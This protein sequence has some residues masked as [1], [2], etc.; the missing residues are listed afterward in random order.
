MKSVAWGDRISEWTKFFVPKDYAM[1]ERYKW[2]TKNSMEV[3]WIKHTI[4]CEWDFSEQT[5]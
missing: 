2:I 5:P 1:D 3:E 4:L